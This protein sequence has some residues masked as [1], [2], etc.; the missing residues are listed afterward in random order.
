VLR[1][2]GLPED[3]VR[4]LAIVHSLP[5]FLA[6][7]LCAQH[8]LGGL[9]R[10]GAAASASPAVFLRI[11][12]DRRAAD[13]AQ[14]LAAE[15]VATAATGHPSI[16]AWTGGGSPFASTAF[17]DGWF[18]VQ[19]PTALRA[20]EA[21]GAAPGMTVV[22]LCAAPGTK[23]TVLA[24]RVRP[25]GCVFAY[26]RD[27][28]RRQ[29]IA[30]NAQR[31]GLLAEI[32]VV[33][34]ASALPVADAVL[35][36][37]PCSNTGVLGRRVEV[38]SRLTAETF[39]G[40]AVQQRSLLEQA[41]RLARP[42]GCVVYSTCSIDR[43]EN[44]DLVRAALRGDFRLEREDLTLPQAGVCDGGY[45]AVLRRIQDPAIDASGQAVRA[46]ASGPGSEPI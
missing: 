27:R 16:L 4:R 43:A 33:A 46:G 39:A 32:R 3:P 28:V 11:A 9:E 41:F 40:L 42:G 35:A 8:G 15:Q 22:D 26:D 17:R 29:R 24:E 45:H 37:V 12:G 1:P 25:G 20:A 30:E 38:R 13:L 21:V 14:V 10:I 6:V 36:D 7:R 19:D 34:D 18:T 2:P 44:E 5:D 31:L 23:T